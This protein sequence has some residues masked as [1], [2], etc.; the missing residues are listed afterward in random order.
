MI[1]GKENDRL[2]GDGPSLQF[3]FNIDNIYKSSTEKILNYLNI[4]YNAVYKYIKRLEYVYDI[5][6][7]NID[8]DQ[9]TIENETS[10][11]LLNK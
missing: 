7:E 6:R 5:Y 4:N 10:K 11:Y 9:N 8:L 3:V 1:C 2:C